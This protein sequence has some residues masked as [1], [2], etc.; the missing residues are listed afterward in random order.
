MHRLFGVSAILVAVSF[1]SPAKAGILGLFGFDCDGTH[2]CGCAR[3]GECGCACE[4]SCGCEPD[5]CCEP[6]CCCE[7]TCGCGVGCCDGRQYA[8]QTW[9]CCCEDC[10]PPICPC[11]DPCG[12]CCHPNCF[13]CAD[14]CG[15][16]ECC[17]PT[18]GCDCGQ[19][20]EPA[21][22]C[23]D[24]CSTCNDCCQRRTCCL[25]NFGFCSCCGHLLGALCGPCGCSGC[26]GELYWSEWHNDP[27]YC[28]D[29]CDCYG[30]FTGPG[31]AACSHG[32]CNV[33]APHSMPTYS[34]S[35]TYVRSKPQARPT[36]VARRPSWNP[37]RATASATQQSARR[38]TPP[39]PIRTATRP[40]TGSHMNAKPQW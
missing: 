16:G 37:N 17:E 40:T 8:G 36:T 30:N 33:G 1:A 5:C 38:V 24:C 10:G 39:A 27:P 21:C 11:K 18:C 9:D 35:E 13:G 14:N 3:G 20:C 23:G 12:N 19:C 25:K 31:A 6:A 29:P 26:D 15:C 22:G 4:A 32:Q 7:P 28:K 34:E 2:N